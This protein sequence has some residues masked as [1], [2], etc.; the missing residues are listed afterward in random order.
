MENILRN[1]GEE[2]VEEKVQCDTSI[3]KDIF[4]TD[5]SACD[6]EALDEGG[7]IRSYWI[8]YPPS[9]C[10]NDQQEKT[11]HYSVVMLLHC[12]GCTGLQMLNEWKDELPGFILVAPQG[13]FNSWN[14]KE[15][16]GYALDK[17][18][19]DVLFLESLLNKIHLSSSSFL[20]AIGFSN[21]GF[22]A[23]YASHL[24][25]A[26]APYSGHISSVDL[27]LVAEKQTS[28][29]LHHALDDR[30]VLD[31]GC[32]SSQQEKQCCCQISQ[33]T[34]TCTST[35]DIF[36]SWSS[37]I[38]GEASSSIETQ[39][40]FQN[41]QQGILCQSSMLPTQQ[42]VTYCQY[43]KGGHAIS[44]FLLKHDFSTFF[45]RDA[46]QQNNNG[47]YHE[48]DNTC[49]CLNGTLLE[50]PPFY[51]QQQNQELKPFHFGNNPD[52]HNMLA[53]DDRIHQI[54]QFSSLWFLFIAILFCGIFIGR[55]KFGHYWCR[56]K[57]GWMAVPTDE[58]NNY[59]LSYR[60]HTTNNS[61]SKDDDTNAHHN[62]GDIELRQRP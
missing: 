3:Q 57:V 49:T 51:C 42:N 19:D 8:Y 17:N 12:F 35:Q 28:V 10:E 61:T 20:Y 11:P 4:I 54:L 58:R 53:I 2:K 15:C 52:N 45:H 22:L 1:R 46:C 13:Y 18:I 21:G 5:S 56:R 33:H 47:F 40:S 55:S 7:C 39:I 23:T 6:P 26:I 60:H 38:I 27:S 62:S 44:R 41:P 25:H 14:A 59:D 32:C 36:H 50:T 37:S 48:N 30:F 43:A 34:E 31:S 16:C 24:F 29:F 9:Y